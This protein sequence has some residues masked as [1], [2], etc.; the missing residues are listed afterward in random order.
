MNKNYKKFH[1]GIVKS[2]VW[3]HFVNILFG[4]IFLHEF[5]KIAEKFEIKIPILIL[6]KDGREEILVSNKFKPSKSKVGI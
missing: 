4:D 6:F 1:N 5:Q 2:L 3:F